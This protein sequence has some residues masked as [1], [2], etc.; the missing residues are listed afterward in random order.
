M[1]RKFVSL[2][3]W[4]TSHSPTDVATCS[5]AQHVL[6]HVLAEAARREHADGAVDA[7]ADV[8]GVLERLPRALEEQPVLRVE[9]G[10]VARAHPEERGVELVDVV[11][12]RGG[13][14][15]RPDR[16]CCRGVSP[17]ASSSSSEKNCIDSTPSR[18][19]AQNVV[20]VRAPG[21]RPAMPMTAMRPSR[22]LVGSSAMAV[23]RP[24]QCPMLLVRHQIASSSRIGRR[25][26]M[27]PS[28][29][30]LIRR[31]ST[32]YPLT[33]LQQG[34]LFHQLEGTNVGVDIEQMVGDL[35]EESTST[36]CWSGVA[37]HRRPPP[38]P[39]DALPLDRS[40]ISRCRRC[41]DSTSAS[42]RRCTT[43]RHLTPAEQAG[44]AR[45][46]HGRGPPARLRARPGA[47]VAR[48]AVPARPATIS[49]SCSPITTR[50]STPA[51][52]G[53]WR[54]SSGPT[55]RSARGE[56][57]RARGAAAVQGPRALAA[58]PPRR[59]SSRCAQAFSRELLDGFDEPTH[60][61][62]A[63]A[64]A[65]R[66]KPTDVGYG[67]DCGSAVGATLSDGIHAFGAAAPA[68]AGGARR[69]GVGARAGGVLRL[70][71][72]RVRLDARRA[73][74]PAC[75]AATHGWG[76]SSTPRRCG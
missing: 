7:L 69:G 35:H 33:P 73:G 66:R 14:A 51:W 17:A 48:H 55:T 44:R 10:G 19:L 36:R 16:G 47:A 67:A 58:R 30:C 29:Q 61:V 27:L 12:R 62:V 21:N 26:P 3:V 54:R 72:R 75:P 46:V 50:C 40:S 22:S 71:R 2:P 42:V 6:E 41:V 59:R 11:E 68:R 52:S 74:V 64:D 57:R 60:L 43:S 1:A 38:D 24:A 65:R 31:R 8:A 76:C 49:G 18:R 32:T 37:A 4:R 56:V 70:H 15:R 45:R 39:A 5:L 13:P 34:M 20:E 28:P 25:D 63:R 23:V 53:W 9:H